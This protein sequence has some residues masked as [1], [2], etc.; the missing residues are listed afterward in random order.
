MAPTWIFIHGINIVD[1]GLI[2]LFFGR[3]LLFFDLFSV[4]LPPGNF[5]D[6][7]LGN[8]EEQY[9]LRVQMQ[10]CRKFIDVQ[11]RIAVLN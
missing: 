9:Y 11:I 7:A 6:D 4:I 8:S 1:S 2:V 5:S 3:F 10:R